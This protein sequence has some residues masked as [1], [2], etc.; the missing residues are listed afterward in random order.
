MKATELAFSAMSATL[1]PS[2]GQK[3][4]SAVHFTAL[5]GNSGESPESQLSIYST[6][7]SPARVSGPQ[8]PF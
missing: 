7:E 6:S 3:Y 8:G 4:G 1:A 5:L 2:F